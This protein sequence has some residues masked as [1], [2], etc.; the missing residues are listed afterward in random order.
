MTQ[1]SMAAQIAEMQNNLKALDKILQE[2]I[3]KKI[4][5]ITVTYDDNTTMTVFAT[6]QQQTKPARKCTTYQDKGGKACIIDGV[7]YIS[8]NAASRALNVYPGGVTSRV[9]SKL[10]PTWVYA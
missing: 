9:Q 10:F 1:K 4:S 2:P 3:E 8:I 6:T 5:S 7:K